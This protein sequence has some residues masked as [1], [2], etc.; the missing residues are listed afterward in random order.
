VRVLIAE[1][2]AIL[3]EGMSQLLTVYGLDVVATAEHGSGLAE[4]LAEV[5]ADIS[6]VDVRLPPRYRDEGLQAAIQ[7]RRAVPGLPVMILSQYVEPLYAAEL[8]A[9]PA[10]GVGYMLKERVGDVA[11]FVTA[12][13][14]V[15]KGGTV[16]DSDVVTRMV[17]TSRSRDRLSTLTAREQQV[18]A[19][20][21]EGRSNSGIAAHLV[22]SDRSVA[23]HISSIL[24]KLNLPPSDDGHRRV[25]AVLTY[26]NG[27]HPD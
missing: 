17:A 4:Q 12:L 10:G 6:I 1:D 3:R 14:R 8:L 11:D 2:L 7:A 9:D 21:A 18:I 22:L 26:L 24:A 27:G 5:R 25:L 15:A 16:M 20:M 19:L 23:K 13:R